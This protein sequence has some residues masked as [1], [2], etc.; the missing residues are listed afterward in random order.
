MKCYKIN[1]NGTVTSVEVKRNTSIKG[2]S[3]ALIRKRNAETSGIRKP[4]N[5]Q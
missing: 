5:A 2:I 4:K 1:T 3:Y